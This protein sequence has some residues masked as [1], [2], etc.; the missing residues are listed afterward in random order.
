MKPLKLSS[1]ITSPFAVVGL[2]SSMGK[3][4]IESGGIKLNEKELLEILKNL[5][6]TGKSDEIVKVPFNKPQTI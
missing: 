6:A 1:A 2:S 4:K 3:V 5:G